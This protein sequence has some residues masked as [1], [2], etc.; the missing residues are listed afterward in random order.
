MNVT[1]YNAITV[2]TLSKLT[3]LVWHG[4]VN[5]HFLFFWSRPTVYLFI[6]TAK[7]TNITIVLQYKATVSP[8]NIWYQVFVQII[9]HLY[10]PYFPTDAAQQLI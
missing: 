7:Q 2:V 1:N 10:F 5:Q 3:K 9:Y 6:E 4:L 8:L